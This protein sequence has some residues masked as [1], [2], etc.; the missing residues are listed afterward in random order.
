MYPNVPWTGKLIAENYVN[1]KPPVIHNCTGV[2]FTG[3]VDSTFTSLKHSEENQLLIT[4]FTLKNALKNEIGWINLQKECSNYG[5]KYGYSNTFIKSNFRDF[6]KT[7][8]LGSIVPDIAIWWGQIQCDLGLAGLVAPLLINKNC[9]KLLIGAGEAKESWGS[10]PSISNNIYWTGFSAKLD[11]YEYARH[12]KIQRIVEMRIQ[13]KIENLT[14]RVCD[15]IENQ[16]NAANCCKCGKCLRTM[17]ALLIE[18]ENV[19][20][21]GF[22]VSMAEAIEQ[23]KLGYIK[24]IR[25]D[26]RFSIWQSLQAR[27]RDILSLQ[28]YDKGNENEIRLFLSWLGSLDLDGYYS[29]RQQR[30]KLRQWIKVVFSRFP[31]MYRGLYK[32]DRVFSKSLFHR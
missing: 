31:L 27:A 12:E 19:K 32:L 23:I 15:Y 16:K 3:G 24:D 22:N 26:S 4:V 7:Q 29:K 2:L 11:G 13:R 30:Q 14:L 8:Y 18:G 28:G 9:G 17:T 1:S 10:H 20:D 5:Q 25:T 21:Y 6:L